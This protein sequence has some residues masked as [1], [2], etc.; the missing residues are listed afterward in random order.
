MIVVDP[1]AK[2]MENHFAHN[3][4]I[5]VDGIPATGEIAIFSSTAIEHV[6]YVIFQTLESSG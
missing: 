1:I 4:V 5:A 2:T 6:I 3:G